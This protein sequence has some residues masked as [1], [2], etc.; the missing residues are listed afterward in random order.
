MTLDPAEG[1]DD[2]L[3]SSPLSLL[4][5]G[6]GA[7][8]GQRLHHPRERDTQP[9]HTHPVAEAQ[10]AVG[11]RVLVEQLEQGRPAPGRHAQLLEQPH[12]I[13]SALLLPGE[14]GGGGWRRCQVGGAAHGPGEPR[15]QRGPDE[16][17]GQQRK[18][19]A[20]VDGAVG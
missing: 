10:E 5:H 19:G 9:R 3:S 8:P 7:G 15:G 20:V 13:H 1:P 14:E 2:L 4:L 12:G 6:R 17:W 16:P 18:L 11:S